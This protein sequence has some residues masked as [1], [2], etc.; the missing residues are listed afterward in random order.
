MDVYYVVLSP[1]N[2]SW[3]EEDIKHPNIHLEPY[4]RD[5]VDGLGI[6]F[7]AV[8]LSSVSVVGNVDNIDLLDSRIYLSN[9]G[10]GTLLFGASSSTDLV[11]SYSFSSGL[12]T[13][14]GV[15][16]MNSSWID[17][18]C[19]WISVGIVNHPTIRNIDIDVSPTFSDRSI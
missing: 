19:I 10:A 5:L 17:R 15:K 9:I 8:F 13:D 2:F 7:D 3:R 18:I 1:I 4:S 16:D 11:I 14:Y 12:G 6:F